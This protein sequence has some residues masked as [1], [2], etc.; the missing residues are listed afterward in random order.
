M[1][2]VD[3]NDYDP[4]TDGKA[5]V[6]DYD[7]KQIVEHIASLPLNDR[8]PCAGRILRHLAHIYEE[9]CIIQA[10]RCFEELQAAVERWKFN[11]AVREATGG[12]STSMRGFVAMPS[13]QAIADEIPC[14]AGTIRNRLKKG[15]DLWRG[16]IKFDGG[17]WWFKRAD[18]ERLL[19]SLQPKGRASKSITE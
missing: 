6:F 10:G 3:Y 12:K 4:E 7:V 15:D 14:D 5:P 11:S 8:L 18:R 9:D 16:A 19:N 17:Q 2:N 1:I 13:L